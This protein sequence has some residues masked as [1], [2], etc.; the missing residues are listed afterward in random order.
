MD[1]HHEELPSLPGETPGAPF[2]DW[3]ADLT[4]FAERKAYQRGIADARYLARQEDGYVT[5]TTNESGEC[6]AV[7]R[8]DEEGR[9]LR[10]LWR[11]RGHIRRMP[12]VLHRKADMENSASRHFPAALVDAADGEGSDL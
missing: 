4:T 11:R 9:V 5:I 12:Q 7:T 1:H 2:P 10:T 8:N 6:V 3:P